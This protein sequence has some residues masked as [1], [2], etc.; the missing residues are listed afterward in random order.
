MHQNQTVKALLP[1][2]EFKAFLQKS[3]EDSRASMYITWSRIRHDSQYQQEEVQYWASQLKHL[4][5][6][7]FDADRASEEPD[8]I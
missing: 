5:S 7:K 1:L 6:I 8:L 4:Q 3:L 2:V